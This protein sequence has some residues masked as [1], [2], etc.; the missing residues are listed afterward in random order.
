VKNEILPQFNGQIKFVFLDFPLEI[1]KNAQPAAQAARAAYAQNKF[2]EMHDKLYESQEE[3]SELRDPKGKFE[4]YARE[5]GL[6][7]DQFKKDFD[8]EA[9]KDAIAQNV[10]LGEAFKLQGTPS[11]FVNGQPVD[12]QQGS[13]SLVAAIKQALGQ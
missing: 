1:H 9:V 11:F 13:D 12:T 3:W 10:A 4:E 7:M 2:W 5:F 6:N 8:S